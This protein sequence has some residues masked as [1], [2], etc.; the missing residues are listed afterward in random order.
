MGSAERQS[1]LPTVVR[2]LLLVKPR[3]SWVRSL[4]SH[5]ADTSF[6]LLAL[7]CT[8]GQNVRWTLRDPVGKHVTG[9]LSL[10]LPLSWVLFS[11]KAVKGQISASWILS[12]I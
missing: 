5:I 9:E 10:C 2:A 11:D 12:L 7:W 6:V 1:S 4:Q 3:A 8:M